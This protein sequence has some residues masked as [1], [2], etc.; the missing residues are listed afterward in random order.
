MGISLYRSLKRFILS[1]DV[2][3]SAGI[4]EFIFTT[5]TLHFNFSWLR[6]S[7]DVTFDNPKF[8]LTFG[9]HFDSGKTFPWFM[10]R[11]GFKVGR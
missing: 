9:V 11:K 3:S 4:F 5:K 2:F 8:L 1:L 7:L 6:S 10:L